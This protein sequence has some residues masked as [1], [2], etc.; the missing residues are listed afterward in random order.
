MYQDYE[1][2][3][4]GV[5]GVL[6]QDIGAATA[7]TVKS[8]N[9]IDI[10]TGNIAKNIGS[11]DPIQIVVMLTEGVT[12]GGAATVQF[13]VALSAA[14]TGTSPE[15]LIETVAYLKTDLPEGT[16]FSLTLPAISPAYL[17]TGMRYLGMNFVVGTATLTAGKINAAVTVDPQ[18]NG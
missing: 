6:S 11:G 4:T 16:A 7:S 17:E 15:V 18:T 2:S 13:Q 1:M 10:G 3:F 12:S 14:E 8:N 9:W 5:A